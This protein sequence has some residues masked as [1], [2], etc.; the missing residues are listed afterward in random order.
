MWGN[1]TLN[2]FLFFFQHEQDLNVNMKK[3]NA[4]QNHVFN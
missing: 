1:Y 2:D 4:S 3:R